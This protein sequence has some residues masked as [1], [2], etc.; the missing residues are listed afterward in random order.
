MIR[1]KH[2]I[3]S[4]INYPGQFGDLLIVFMETICLYFD[5]VLAMSE[6]SQLLVTEVM[7]I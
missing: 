6:I 7:C 5:D 1:L 3:A 4:L 2:V